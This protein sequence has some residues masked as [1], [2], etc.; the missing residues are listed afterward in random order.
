[1]R[2]SATSTARARNVNLLW[3]HRKL[4]LI[5]HGAALVFQHQWDGYLAR[6]A[7][8][9]MPIKDH[10]LLP[11]GQRAGRG[12]CHAVAAARRPQVIDGIVQQIPDAWLADDALFAGRDA[13]REAYRE[14]FHRAAAGAARLCPGSSQRA[15]AQL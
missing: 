7:L 9:F 4:W 12:R 15:H 1:M 6:S 10:V 5:D 8:P 3:W 13:Q 11:L 14:H 2:S